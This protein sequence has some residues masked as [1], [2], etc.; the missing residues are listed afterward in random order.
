MKYIIPINEYSDRVVGFKYSE[1]NEKCKVFLLCSGD[2]NKSKF[3]KALSNVDR[4][5]YDTNSIKID[6]NQEKVQLEKGVVLPEYKVEFI[7]NVYDRKEVNPIV[8]QLTDI[9][10]SVYNI[11]VFTFRYKKIYNLK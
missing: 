9:L 1:P 4:V 8:E 6:R 10:Y 3:I 5:N 2:I 11:H 7:L